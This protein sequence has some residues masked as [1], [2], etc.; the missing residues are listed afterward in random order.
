MQLKYKK[1]QLKDINL[2]QKLEK[3]I[4]FIDIN[5]IKESKKTKKMAKDVSS[6]KV[7]YLKVKKKNAQ[8]VLLILSEKDH[9]SRLDLNNA[10]IWRQWIKY[11][12]TKNKK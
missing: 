3:N 2:K 4:A 10:D 6:D 8:T 5:L 1:Q 9:I 12:I 11:C 7:S